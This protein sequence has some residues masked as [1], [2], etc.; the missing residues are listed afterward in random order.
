VAAQSKGPAAHP[1]LFRTSR[2]VSLFDRGS[3]GLGGVVTSWLRHGPRASTLSTRP[4]AEAINAEA[5]SF[6]GFFRSSSVS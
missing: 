3:G 4:R 5:A 1:A 6:A 2:C